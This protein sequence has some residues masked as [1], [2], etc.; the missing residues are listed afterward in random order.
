M[1][2][3]AIATPPILREG[4]RLTSAEFLHRWE[5]MPDLRWAEL[6][7]GVV[8]MPSPVSRIHGNLH[9]RLSGWLCNYI[10]HTPGC[11]IG[12]DSTWVMS[13]LDVPQPDI[14]LR[15]LE[16]CGGQSRDSGDYNDGAPELIVEVSGSTL[17]RDL[18]IKLELYRK[19]G[20]REY[21]TILLKPQRVIWRELS[22]GRY[23][24][25]EPAEDDGLLRSRYFPG[26]W[27]DPKALW[28]PKQSLRPAIEQGIQTPEHAA[29]VSRLAKPRRRRK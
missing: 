21:I 17:S 24:E 4:D 25:I 13:E 22:R 28:D 11:E 2:N 26:L 7:D 18:G 15:I 9:G 14:S 3:A 12:L 10:D 29:F 20:V 5:A 19:A 23:R 6:I 27:L 8:F 16:A 1:A